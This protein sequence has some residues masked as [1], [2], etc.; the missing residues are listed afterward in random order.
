MK[1]VVSLLD[2]YHSDQVGAMWDRLNREFGLS[3]V[4]ECPYPHVAFHTA[5]DYDFAALEIVLRRFSRTVA[6]F[7]VRTTGLSI[8]MEEPPTLSIALVRSFDLFRFHQRLW[9]EVAETAEG[10]R[11]SCFGDYWMPGITLATDDVQQSLLPNILWTLSHQDFKWEFTI[12]NLCYVED[13][14]SAGS[15][16]VLQ[17]DLTGEPERIINQW[18]SQ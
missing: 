15:R 17:I 10:A 16:P 13:M 18:G 5:Q 11:Q 8:I 7:R 12:D 6:P 3:G 4:Y 14:G 1:G 2:S 9:Y